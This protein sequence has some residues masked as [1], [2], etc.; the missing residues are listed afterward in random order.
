[1]TRISEIET[2]ELFE[3]EKFEQSQVRVNNRFYFIEEWPSIAGLPSIIKVQYKADDQTY[4]YYGTVE[5]AEYEH[6]KPWHP[7][8]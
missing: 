2:R 1:M 6:R 7:A 3:T 4:W 8:P 5:D